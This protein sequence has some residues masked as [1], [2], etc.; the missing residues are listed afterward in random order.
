MLIHKTSGLGKT[1]VNLLG[2]L[3]STTE[4][5]TPFD[6][7]DFR[8]WLWDRLVDAL[9]VPPDLLTSTAQPRRWTPGDF[10][11]SW[12]PAELRA[13]GL[14]WSEI[15]RLTMTS[16]VRWEPGERERLTGDRP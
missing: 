8:A 13:F 5:P 16:N 10:T 9:S 12:T 2:T 4:T 7:E 15:E 6:V 1:E 11:P 3:T 14:G